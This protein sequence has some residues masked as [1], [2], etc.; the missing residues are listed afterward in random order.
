[1]YVPSVILSNVGRCDVN[2]KRKSDPRTLRLRMFRKCF[3]HV[4]CFISLSDVDFVV[5]VGGVD[6]EVLVHEDVWQLV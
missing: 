5:C 6:I 4:G 2:D 3:R 1:M